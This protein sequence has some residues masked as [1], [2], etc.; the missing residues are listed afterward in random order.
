MLVLPASGHRAIALRLFRGGCAGGT[1]GSPAL[2]ILSHAQDRADCRHASVES[3]GDSAASGRV[4]AAACATLA[5]H[6]P[7]QHRISCPVNRTFA[8]T[9]V[10]SPENDDPLRQPELDFLLRE[11]RS[12]LIAIGANVRGPTHRDRG[13]RHAKKKAQELEWFG[14]LA[15]N[16]GYVIANYHGL[17]PK[18]YQRIVGR[19][20]P[21]PSRTW[22]ED[23]PELPGL[24]VL[25]LSGARQ[26]DARN[27]SDLCQNRERWTVRDITAEAADRIAKLVDLPG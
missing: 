8:I 18:A 24:L 2:A 9:H 27:V 15:R 22:R 19:V 3:N 1:A 16:G 7:A 21:G 12:P 10:I 5:S 25:K 20:D 14:D 26:I 11:K 4:D 23:I 17:S 6:S 13:T